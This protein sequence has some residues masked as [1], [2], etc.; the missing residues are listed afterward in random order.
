MKDYR[1]NQRVVATLKI[2]DAG[3]DFIEID[4]LE[5]GVILGNSIMFKDGKL[6]LIGIGTNDGIDYFDRDQFLTDP[7]NLDADFEADDYY[8]YFKETG[9]NDPL[10][11]EAKT[12]KYKVEGVLRAEKPNRFLKK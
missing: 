2:E 3:Q 6:T 7:L 9:E 12:L 10:P 5:N 4:V 8:I 1:Q 11:W